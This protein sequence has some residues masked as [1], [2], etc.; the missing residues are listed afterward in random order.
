MFF[1]RLDSTVYRLHYY[2]IHAMKYFANCRRNHVAFS[3][4]L[5]GRNVNQSRPALTLSESIIRF[6][7]AWYVVTFDAHS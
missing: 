5:L 3:T 2:D 6:F 1:M 4:R 7:S